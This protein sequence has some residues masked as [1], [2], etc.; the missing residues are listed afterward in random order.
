MEH[1]IAMT[2]VGRTQSSAANSEHESSLLLGPLFG[3]ASLHFREWRRSRRDSLVSYGATSY[4]LSKVHGAVMAAIELPLA[5]RS[6][7]HWGAMASIDQPV[8]ALIIDL[9]AAG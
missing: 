5:A 8:L 1:G 4:G 7:R 9:C 2:S 6:K 3:E